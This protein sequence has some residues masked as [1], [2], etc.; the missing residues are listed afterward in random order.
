MV[1]VRPRSGVQT[2]LLSMAALLAALVFLALV[3]IAAAF[4]A[5]IVLAAFNALPDPDRKWPRLSAWAVALIPAAA[6]MLAFFVSRRGEGSTFYAQQSTNRWISVLLLVTIIGLL[7]ALGE[8]IAATLT[9]NSYGALVGAG[10]ASMA[11]LGAAGYAQLRGSQAVL[12]SARAR[13][14]DPANH[15]MLL[16][17]VREL[18]IAADM[19]PPAVYVIGDP[20]P[21]A[22]AVGTNQSN[23]AIAVTTGALAAFDREQLQGVVGHELSHIRN[24][25]SRYGVYVAV[26]VGL[27]ALV[28]DGFLRIVVEAWR[29]GVF[30]R[31]A[32]SDDSKG[33]IAGLALGV[34]AGILLLLVAAVLRVFAP[35]AS[36]FVQAAVSRQR[37]Y[38]ADAT[39]VELTRN[40]TGLARALATIRGNPL[41]LAD[42][43]RGSQ[44]LWF[45]SP[46]GHDDDTGWHLLATHP[47]LEA[48]I[49]RL[50][51][52]YRRASPAGR[53]RRR[54]PAGGPLGAVEGLDDVRDQVVHV[55]DADRQPDKRVR[56]LERRVGDRA[57]GHDRRDLAQRLHAAE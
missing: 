32:E 4:V 49:A 12:D 42:A 53:A 14:A 45:N 25:D 34:G 37:E 10:L 3:V 54:H 24:L 27:V 6:L 44:H 50:S 8:A 40:P 1:V 18:S 5:W 16:D 7:V 57:V 21:N 46:L 20:S 41:P 11:G 19:P 55:L 9:F 13:P 2:L 38:L 51:T 26:L 31:G 48:R 29:N 43:N 39:S 23:A 47:T 35:L 52:L 22:L 56:D 28:T 30:L 33:A 17:V 15:K 36:L